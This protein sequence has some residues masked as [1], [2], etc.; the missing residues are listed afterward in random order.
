MEETEPMRYEEFVK[1]LLEQQI[2]TGILEP[3]KLPQLGLYVDQAASL[4]NRQL[5]G[6]RKDQKEEGITKSMVNNYTKHRLLPRPIN[7]KYS[8]DHLILMTYVLQLKG[9]LSMQDIQLLIKPLVENQESPYEDKID[10]VELY[11]I[12]GE[13]QRKEQTCLLSETI[14]DME[15]IKGSLAEIDLAEDD[16]L[17]M[18]LL[19]VN[20][21]IR[22]NE[23][24]A[25]AEQLIQQFYVRPTRSTSKTAAKVDAEIKAAAKAM[26]K[27]EK[28]KAV[29]AAKAAKAAKT[30]KTA[31]PSEPAKTAK[32]EKTT[33]SPL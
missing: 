9:I 16:M 23:Q 4:L 1:K 28:A 24:K 8:S 11:R 12:T 17:G 22:A 14:K 6:E 7:K 26:A 32:A 3:A 2:G 21:S 29:K 15:Q 20:L 25:L 27:A 30:A 19:A 18:F 33:N 31:K 10:L 13:L 5:I